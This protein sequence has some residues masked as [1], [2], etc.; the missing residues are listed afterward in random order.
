[1]KRS[2]LSLLSPRSGDAPSPPFSPFFFRSPIGLA[3][4]RS[5]GS[6]PF[7]PSFSADG[8]PLRSMPFSMTWWLGLGA[9]AG[10]LFSFSF[11]GRGF[12]FFPPPTL[13][14]QVLEVSVQ[15]VFRDVRFEREWLKKESPPPSP[16]FTE[17]QQEIERLFTLASFF[18]FSSAAGI[19]GGFFPPDRDVPLFFHTDPLCRS[20]T[21][22]RQT[23]RRSTLS[24]FLNDADR[25]PRTV[26]FFFFFFCACTGAE[27]DE[28]IA[29]FHMS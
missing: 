8:G 11:Q 4:G 17:R 2:R 29:P 9:I 12:F 22:D 7:P 23:N 26:P 20:G 24:F 1:M 15:T 3:A 13:D 25:A 18:S 27:K 14:R 5:R 16:F 28:R 10:L 21:S 19:E 6:P